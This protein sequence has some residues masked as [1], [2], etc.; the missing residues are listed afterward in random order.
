MEVET[1]DFWEGLAAQVGRDQGPI[2][3]DIITS[4]RDGDAS[5]LKI[6]QTALEK[7][8]GAKEEKLKVTDEQFKQIIRLAA[9]RI[10]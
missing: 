8:S 7:F 4:A 3:S 5:A 6:V 1:Q 10:K 2:I 9:D